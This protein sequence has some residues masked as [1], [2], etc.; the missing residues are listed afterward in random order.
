MKIC[1]A[2]ISSIKGDIQRNIEKHKEYILEA[3]DNK[4]DLICFPELSITGYEP[5]LAKEL[6][7][8]KDDIRFDEFQ[9]LADYNDITICIGVP[10][11]LGDDIY[12]SM[13][14]FQPLKERKTY[15][16]QYLHTD[17]K[18]YFTEGKEH[19]IIECKGKSI[20]PAICYE[21]LIP[22]HFERVKSMNIDLYM[23]S[24]AKPEKNIQNAYA[25]FPKLANDNNIHVL[26]VNSVGYSD[27]FLATGQS[28]VWDSHGVL[29]QQL[30]SSSGK[31]LLIE[32]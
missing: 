20:A 25:Y 1:L 23:A 11:V 24:V 28:A 32:I 10:T 15:S 12:I 13:V 16:K 19:I 30:N 17:E 26:M 9:K 27:D 31:L 14:I 2:Q 5:E 6:A 18:P 8:T 22:E 29:E 4:A 21:S 3:I 7:T